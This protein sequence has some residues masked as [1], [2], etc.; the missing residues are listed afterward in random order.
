MTTCLLVRHGQS[1]AN[2]GGTLAGHLDVPLTAAGTEQA[3]RVAAALGDVPLAHVITSPL[4]RCRATAEVICALQQ[5]SCRLTADDA[6][7]EVRYGAWTGRHLK[8]LAQ[9]D[10]WGT[11]QST[12]SHVTFP[13]DPDGRHESE[14]MSEM[15]ERVWAGWDSWERRV[16]QE[17]GERAVWM[18]VS[19]GDVIKALLARALGLELDAFQSIVI[20][21]G[22]VSLVHRHKDRTAVLGMNLRDDAYTRLAEVAAESEPTPQD[23]HSVGVLGGGDA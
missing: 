3:R 22:S 2:V 7:A 8:E 21:P 15:A 9:E 11:I 17:H 18:A 14:S 19:H 5:D 23:E 1:E 4:R 6:F 13:A 10:L 20:D 12:P 16:A